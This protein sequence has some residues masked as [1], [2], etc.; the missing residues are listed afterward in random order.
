[1]KSGS[2]H[3]Q[4]QTLQLQQCLGEK[5]IWSWACKHPA[6]AQ[7]VGHTAEGQKHLQQIFWAWSKGA[8]FCPLTT[9]GVSGDR[10]PSLCASAG[11][12]K[13]GGEESKPWLFAG[14]S[15]RHRRS[16][17]LL[18]L[19][20]QMHES[21]VWHLSLVHWLSFSWNPGVW[22]HSPDKT[23]VFVVSKCHEAVLNSPPA[24]PS[25][26]LCEAWCWVL[27]AHEFP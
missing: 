17:E 14:P 21:W 27:L 3:S 19:R 9:E 7:V 5:A 4:P 8:D 24:A 6:W 2:S 15:F 20:G 18:S 16:D 26:L 22:T 11:C 23:G 25:W 12:P 1:M 13:A 10:D